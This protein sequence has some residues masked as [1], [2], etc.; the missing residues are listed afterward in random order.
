MVP[1]AAL[2]AAVREPVV[3]TGSVVREHEPLDMTALAQLEDGPHALL[4]GQEPVEPEPVHPEIRTTLEQLLEVLEV[5]GVTTVPD[6]DPRQIDALRLEHLL[7]LE[8]A[9]GG[10]FR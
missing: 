1:R 6:H 3:V 2:E 8:A 4:E 5:G 7:L 9:P 10:R